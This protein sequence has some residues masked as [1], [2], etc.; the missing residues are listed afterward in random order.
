MQVRHGTLCVWKR[1]YVQFGRM[2]L[3]TAS[4]A[5]WRVAVSALRS[6]APTTQIPQLV[7]SL[8][9]VC[10]V[11]IVRLEAR[12]QAE[13]RAP[14]KVTRG[15]SQHPVLDGTEAIQHQHVPTRLRASDVCEMVNMRRHD[16][17]NPEAATGK[18]KR[19]GALHSE[20]RPPRSRIQLGV[21]RACHLLD[22]GDH[23]TR[24]FK[25]RDPSDEGSYAE[26]R[27][28]ARVY[29]HLQRR[30]VHTSNADI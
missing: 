26:R 2:V 9:R 11:G 10:C 20:R 15:G 23:A 1:N 30:C 7:A 21:R 18:P 29:T 8:F 5:S 24:V 25:Q 19:E 16:V 27:V 28:Q 3:A 17:R 13:I 14:P 12:L 4:S 6:F 22:S